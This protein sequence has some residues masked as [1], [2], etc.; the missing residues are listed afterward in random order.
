MVFAGFGKQIGSTYNLFRNLLEWKRKHKFFGHVIALSSIRQHLHDFF[1][2]KSKTKAGKLFEHALFFLILSNVVFAALETI[3]SLHQQFQAFFGWFNMISVMIF[4]VEFFLRIWVADL[5]KE[6]S[7]RFGRVRF[8][9]SLPMLFDL[10]VILPFY[11]QTFFNFD[12]RV[13]RVFRLIR[14]FRIMR[15]APYS[16]ALDRILAVL[17][18]EKEELI[19][20]F[21]IMIMS[22]FITSTMLYMAE[23][24]VEGTQFTSIPASFWWGIATLTTIGYGDMVPI[25]PLGKV[26]GSFAAIIGVGIFALPTGLLGASFY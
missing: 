2:Y 8:S 21:G 1:E 10:A 3:A 7:S 25:T 24:H 4:T 13:L 26:F 23:N 19:A 18:R 17:R 9:F 20:I 14:I 16:I 11:L 5:K 6:Y 22:L 15:L 12:A